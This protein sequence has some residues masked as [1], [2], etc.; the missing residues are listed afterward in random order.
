MNKTEDKATLFVFAAVVA[1]WCLFLTNL[2]NA[3]AVA[4]Y[5]FF[6][7]TGALIMISV[8]ML[9]GNWIGRSIRNQ[10]L[11]GLAGTAFVLIWCWI[12]FA[13]FINSLLSG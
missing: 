2:G 10:M 9:L 7:G 12:G 13:I 1:I 4:R 6:A 11:F 3:D 5:L 8:G